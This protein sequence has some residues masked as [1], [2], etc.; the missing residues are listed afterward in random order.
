MTKKFAFI[1]LSLG[2]AAALLGAMPSLLLPKK[3]MAA[4]SQRIDVSE[5]GRSA[6]KAM[7]SFDDMHQRHIGVLDVL[8]AQ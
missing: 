3:S 7:M 5:I 8:K 2:L 6:S 4:A 1:A